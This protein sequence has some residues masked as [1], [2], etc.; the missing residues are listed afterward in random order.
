MCWTKKSKV[1]LHHEMNGLLLPKP[2]L[3]V[4]AEVET[5][6]IKSH[7]KEGNKSHLISYINSSYLFV[8]AGNIEVL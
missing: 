2:D 7:W 3:F 8:T 5:E 6:Q 4:A 1:Q